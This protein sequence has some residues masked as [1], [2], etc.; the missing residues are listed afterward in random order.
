MEKRRVSRNH[1]HLDNSISSSSIININRINVVVDSAIASEFTAA[2]TAFTALAFSLY[3]ETWTNVVV[4][5]GTGT[6]SVTL[7]SGDASVTFE[8]G[9]TTVTMSAIST[10][11]NQ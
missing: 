9:K 11:Y 3:A 5:L 10:Q 6:A 1:Q 7:S 2:V 8:I 4:T